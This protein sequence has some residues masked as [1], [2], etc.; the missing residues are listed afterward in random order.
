MLPAGGLVRLHDA[1]AAVTQPVTTLVSCR[2]RVFTPS[3]AV[4]V[5]LLP[6]PS[7]ALIVFTTVCPS[8][9]PRG[10]TILNCPMQLAPAGKSNLGERMN[11][12]SSAANCAAL[13]PHSPL[14]VSVPWTN[15]ALA[16]S[17]SSNDTCGAQFRPALD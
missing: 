13:A 4:A 3:V 5:A 7:V 15:T 1:P 10:T 14:K 16:G 9:V 8:C 17:V 12:E 6:A 2:S 11:F